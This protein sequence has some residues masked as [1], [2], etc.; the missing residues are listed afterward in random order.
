MDE[1]PN[2]RNKAAFSDGMVWMED[3][4]VEIKLLF[5]SEVQCQDGPQ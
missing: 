5:F 3:L 4:T 1:G 2:Q